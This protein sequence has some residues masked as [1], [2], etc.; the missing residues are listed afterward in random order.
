MNRERVE[1]ELPWYSIFRVNLEALGILVLLVGTFVAA[2]GQIRSNTNEITDLKATKQDTKVGDA[3][4][5][6]LLEKIANLEKQVGEVKGDTKEI[7]ARIEALSDHNQI[8][9]QR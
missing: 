2:E 8:Q 1:R 3:Q 4:Q 6:V 5:Q 9:K 7:R